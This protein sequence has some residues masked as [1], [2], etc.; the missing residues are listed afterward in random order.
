MEN[1]CSCCKSEYCLNVEA[2]GFALTTTGDKVTA[3]ASAAACSET[4][5]EDAW[6]K[7]TDLAKL[8]A[9]IEAK[10][11]ANIIDQ[12]LIIIRSEINDKIKNVKGDTGLQGIN[13]L[14]GLQGINGLQGLKG[15]SGATGLQ[16]L[17]GL[18]GATGLQGLQGLN[19][20]VG[21][22]GLQGLNGLQ[23]IQGIQGLQ[24]SS[25]LV[26]ATGLTPS[27]SNF[28]TTNTDQTIFGYKTFN[29]SILQSIISP[30]IL[31]GTNVPC[32]VSLSSIFY[33]TNPTNNLQLDI[34]NFPTVPQQ[35]VPYCIS[36]II[37]KSSVTTFY[38]TT[39]SINR[40]PPITPF[41]SNGITAT[42]SLV[43]SPTPSSKAN[44]V[45]QNF[46]LIYIGSVLQSILCSTNVSY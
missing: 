27:T 1:C 45:V 12:T 26:G 39:I 11:S 21:A 44:T 14:Q 8:N 3:T 17:N 43:S 5:Y 18:V 2:E 33:V 23:G 35:N 29:N 32:D 10:N 25:G 22:T 42:S 15:N 37:N 4:S 20:L 16:G 7:A 40:S 46:N 13:G 28:V 30:T 9:N 19:G 36:L 38:A 24:G 34:Q 31:N 6:F 41:F